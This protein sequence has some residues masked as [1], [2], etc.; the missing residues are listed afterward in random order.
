MSNRY[1]NIYNENY[2]KHYSLG[3]KSVYYKEY[4]PLKDFFDNLAEQ[5]VKTI[6]PKTVLDVGCAMGLFVAA[7]RDRGVEAYGID[8]SEFAIENVRDDVK[9]FCKV[10]EAQGKLPESFPKKFDLVV[11]IEMIEHL[12]AE[13]GDKVIDN[14]C[15]YTNNIIFSSTDSEI[16]DP[17]HLNVKPA[18]YWAKRFAKNGFYRSVNDDM[19][20]I[21]SQAAFFK[22]KRVAIENLVED[23]EHLITVS[24]KANEDLSVSKKTLTAKT[25]EQKAKIDKLNGE[26][27]ILKTQNESLNFDVKYLEE[28]IA[29]QS[30]ELEVLSKE[31]S[32]VLGSYRAV[33]GSVFWKVSNPIR[34][35]ADKLKSGLKKRGLSKLVYIGLASLKNEGVFAFTSKFKHWALKSSAAKKYIK[36]NMPSPKQIKLERETVFDKKVKVSILVPL[37]NTPLEF[38]K[39]MIQSVKDQTYTNWELCMA[40]GS[41]QDHRYVGKTAL[42][43]AQNDKRIKYKKLNKNYGISG[44]TNKCIEM[45]SGDY[46]ALFDHDDLLHPSALFDVVTAINKQNADFIYTDECSFKGNIFEPESPHFKP[47]FSPDSLRSYNYICHLS[48][49]SHELL[50][51]VGLFSKN[52]DGS[53]D[54][55]MILRLTEKAKKI[56]HI[57]RILYFWRIHESSVANNIEAKPYCIQ[58]AKRAIKDHLDRLHLNG[59][60]TDSSVI[61]TYKINYKIIGRPMISIIIPNKDHIEDLKKCIAS[62]T[63][64]SSYDNYEIIIVENNSEEERTFSYYKSLQNNSKIKVLHFEGEFNYSAINNFGFKH[65][66][67]EYILLLNNDVE[68]INRDW[69]QEML[70]FAQRKD[71][72]AVGAKLLYP[73]DKIQHAGVILGINGVAGHA[74]KGWDK[75]SPGY[76]ARI[77]IAHNVSA[78]TAACLMMSKEVFLEVGGLDESFAVAF[79]D[80]DL[81]MRIREA[82]YLIVYTPYAQLYHYESK[83]RG[84]EDT[85]VK[86]KR[87][88]GEVLKFQERWKKA[89]KNGDPYYN[90]NLTLKAEDFSFKTKEEK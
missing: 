34:H 14:I 4:K 9:P 86:R 63:S 12:D 77:S 56:V 17:T 15:S 67:G 90:R 55:D 16:N 69:L 18:K 58:S 53:Q 13:D 57:P 82:G 78:V 2:Y 83:S 32:T 11:S 6:N 10:A 42:S 26:N 8:I 65:S 54:Y 37:Y 66:S 1:E 72:G 73:D 81:C 7:L 39:E 36:N 64:K 33:T 59:E 68:V 89:L 28:R 50:N 46:I 61:T 76:A 25:I 3:N 84:Y 88:V 79:N 24:N 71:I 75:D 48:V 35:S 80:I 87:F 47:D 27:D 22:R 41:D 74:H 70:M 31:L 43:F 23:Y 44:N 52:H 38:L 85:P 21:S 40:D 30:N 45:A 19:S 29:L 62:I 60:V 20:F 5:V 51:E 49:F